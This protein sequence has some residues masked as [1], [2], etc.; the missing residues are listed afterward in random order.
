MNIRLE[1]EDIEIGQVVT[2]AVDGVHYVEIDDPDPEEKPEEKAWK[3]IRAVAN[4]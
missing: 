1:I 2:I 4:E 3:N